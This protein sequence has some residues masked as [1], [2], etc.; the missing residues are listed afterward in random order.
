MKKM[1][2]PSLLV[3]FVYAAMPLQSMNVLR[4]SVTSI[5]M[6]ELHVRRL[7]NRLEEIQAID[8]ENLSRPQR[9]EMRKEIKAIKRTMD[10]GGVYISVGALILI[11]I[12]L[13]ILI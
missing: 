5:P 9:K 4:P 6:S 13:I 11:I 8:K 7:S 1:L 10:G 3:M 2:K 12:L